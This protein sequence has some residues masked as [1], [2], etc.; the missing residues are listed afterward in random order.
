MLGGDLSDD[1]ALG[2]DV[3]GGAGDDLGAVEAF[4]DVGLDDLA[5]EG[6]AAVGADLRG[7]DG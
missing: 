2:D 3:V 6:R 1:G 5:A 7:R 4:D